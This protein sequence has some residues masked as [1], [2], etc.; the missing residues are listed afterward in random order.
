MGS[1]AIPD[2]LL[3]LTQNTM[4]ISSMTPLEVGTMNPRLYPRA[5]VQG[6]AVFTVD[7]IIGEGQVLDL[8]LP[9][10]LVDSPLSPNKGD[11]LTLCLDI[12]HVGALFNIARGVVRWVQ[13]SRFGVEFIEMD[14]RERFQYNAFIDTLLDEQVGNQAA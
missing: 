2:L 7:G 14:L 9:G 8:T 4:Q 5:V 12:P 11:S 3:R 1:L 6:S 13:G 10:C